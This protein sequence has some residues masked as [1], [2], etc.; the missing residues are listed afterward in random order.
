MPWRS[1]LKGKLRKFA[2]P[3]WMGGRSWQKLED[4]ALRAAVARYGVRWR[5]AALKPALAGRGAASLR[6][7]WQK[8]S[9]LP[10]PVAKAHAASDAPVSGTSR[11]FE[12]HTVVSTRGRIGRRTRAC[13]RPWDYHMSTRA[14]PSRE[15]SLRQQDLIRRWRLNEPGDRMLLC[16]LHRAESIVKRWLARNGRDAD[17]RDAQLSL[18]ER[19]ELNLVYRP[20]DVCHTLTSSVSNLYYVSSPHGRAGF[21]T[22]KLHGLEPRCR[23][24]L[25]VSVRASQA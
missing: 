3:R 13:G 15:P 22:S 21:A 9:Q 6:Q 14:T 16:N 1:R 10:A 11:S 20:G 12:W 24:Q 19:D 25:K 4:D 8:L 23:S 5:R 18:Q 2:K 17:V 7:R